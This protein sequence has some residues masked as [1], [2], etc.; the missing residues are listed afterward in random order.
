[1]KRDSKINKMDEIEEIKKK[2]LQQM[3]QK[4][5]EKAQSQMPDQA[6]LQQQIGQLENAVKP[7]FTKDALERYGNLKTAHPKKAV[8]LLVI[9]AQA[10]QSGKIQQVDG[11]QL[12]EILQ[13]MEPE[14]K[15]FN[16]KK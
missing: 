5:Q 14:K 7:V 9:L 1:M 13:K 2:K 4:Q 15:D 10:I 11:K 8:Q 3:M 12:K 16:I 6:E